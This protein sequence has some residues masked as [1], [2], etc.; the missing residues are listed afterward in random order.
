MNKNKQYAQQ[1]A[2]KRENMQEIRFTIH[3]NSYEEVDLLRR[4]EYYAKESNKSRNQCIK[5]AIDEY[6]TKREY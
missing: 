5:E 2:W 4:L 6:L 3:K 1:N